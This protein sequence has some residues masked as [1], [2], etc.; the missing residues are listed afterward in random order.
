MANEK[1]NAALLASCEAM[2]DL[3]TDA[4]NGIDEYGGNSRI[5]VDPIEAEAKANIARA[6]AQGWPDGS[7]MAAKVGALKALIGEH[8]PLPWVVGI[9]PEEATPTYLIGARGAFFAR[10]VDGPEHRGEANARY[11]V[12]AC[13]NFP[14]LL[15][16]LV[17]MEDVFATYLEDGALT[18]A[19]D[20]APVCS[21]AIEEAQAALEEV[22]KSA[23][24]DTE[25][26][27]NVDPGAS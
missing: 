26:Q 5:T 2:L 10:V 17:K 27:E 7:E 13:N 18:F 19:K 23:A 9:A 11:I 4:K 20:V 16:A 24:P 15:A 1:I 12:R 25:G 6:K 14:G 22:K 21:A 3:M 8:T